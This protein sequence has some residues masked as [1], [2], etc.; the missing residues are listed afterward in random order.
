MLCWRILYSR[1]SISLVY[2]ERQVTICGK[3]KAFA[4]ACEWREKKC[5]FFCSL[6]AIISKV[7]LYLRTE[8][9]KSTS[10]SSSAGRAQ[11]CQGWGR[12]FESRLSLSFFSYLHAQVVELVDT[13]DL[14]SCGQ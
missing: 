2:R 10:E 12:E 5:Y 4:T 1:L 9:L 11:P 7:I 6:V 13:Q 8:L 3:F 14:K